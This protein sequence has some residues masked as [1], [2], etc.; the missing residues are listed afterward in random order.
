MT[1]LGVPACAAVAELGGCS[2]NP[3]LAFRLQTVNPV[4]DAGIPFA[5]RDSR[6]PTRLPEEDIGAREQAIQAAAIDS[7]RAFRG[8]EAP[9]AFAQEDI[10]AGEKSEESPE[11]DAVDSSNDS[12]NEPGADD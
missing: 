5:L 10:G 11:G 12:S 6:V 9:E 3:R 1:R 7:I 4:S 8:S 2:G